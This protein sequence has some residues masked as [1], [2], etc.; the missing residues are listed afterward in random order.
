MKKSYTKILAVVVVVLVAIA[1]AAVTFAQDAPT[2]EAPAAG[3]AQKAPFMGQRGLGQRPE[4]G[5]MENIIDREAMHA[6]LAD[7]L[8]LS[9]AE[10]DAAHA[11]GK[12][13]PEIAEAQG[14]ALADVEAAMQAAWQT[15]V[16]DALTA[17]TITQEQADRL[18]E[19]GG[20]LGMGA[21]KGGMRGDGG[22]METIFTPEAMHATIAQA[23]G[24]TVDELEAAHVDG[25]RLPEIA[26]A[27]GVTMEAVQTAVEAARTTAI[28]QALAAGTIT[29][30]QAD[31]LLSHPW[32]PGGHGSRGPRGG[33]FGGPRGNGAGFQPFAPEGDNGN[34]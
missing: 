16:N 21:P 10:L 29:Q 20:R 17:G 3:M 19:R 23:L 14:V 5:M 18:L 25:Q 32:Q 13:L 8:G 6:T 24:M 34:A 22:L 9:V 7:V 31:M 33:G 12:R 15:A 4:R 26:E 11:E 30:E 1:G 2:Q 27:Q 28:E